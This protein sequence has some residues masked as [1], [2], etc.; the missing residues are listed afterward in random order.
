MKIYRHWALSDQG[1]GHGMGSKFFS[2]YHNKKFNSFFHL[3]SLNQIFQNRLRDFVQCRRGLHFQHGLYISALE[4]ARML[5]L[6]SYIYVLLAP[7]NTI[8]WMIL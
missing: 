1:Q 8:N 2:I 5:I 3:P 6:S 4:H 7:I